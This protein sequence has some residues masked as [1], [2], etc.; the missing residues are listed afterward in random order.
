MNFWEKLNQ[1]MFF[2][3]ITNGGFQAWGQGPREQIWRRKVK[4]PFH[5]PSLF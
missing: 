1:K 2:G 3:V 5:A 4:N